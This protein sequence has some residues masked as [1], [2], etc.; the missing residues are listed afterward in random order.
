VVQPLFVYTLD[1]GDD[2]F[3]EAMWPKANPNLNVSVDI[4][5]LR[6][7]AK[8]AKNSPAS[9]GE[10]KTKRLNVWQNSHS[11]W[12]SVEQWKACGDTTLKIEDFAGES[13]WIGVDLADTNDVA[14]LVIVFDRD[15]LEHYGSAQIAANLMGDGLP[16]EIIHKKPDTYSE[17]AKLLEAWVEINKLR[18]DANPVLTWMASNCVVDRRVNGSILPKKEHKDSPKKIDGSDDRA[19]GIRYV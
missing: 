9:L 8:Q 10:F 3:N 19:E 6:A 14:A 4:E 2:P 12:L 15:R 13:A 17:P 1:E 16:V 5:K 7:Y 11:T 18:F